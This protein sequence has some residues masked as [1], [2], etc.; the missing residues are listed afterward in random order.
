[1][2]AQHETWRT[3]NGVDDGRLAERLLVLSLHERLS[4]L[5][6]WPA[7]S[8]GESEAAYRRV[9][10]VVAILT[11]TLT[12]IGVSLIWE[13]VVVKV[14][15]GER[16]EALLCVD[17]GNGSTNGKESGE[18]GSGDHN[19]LF[20]YEGISASLG[21]TGQGR[22]KDQVVRPR[23]RTNS[24]FRYSSPAAEGR[25]QRMNYGFRFGDGCLLPICLQGLLLCTWL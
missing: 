17:E 13:V 19:A 6:Q 7:G 25:A 22:G 8:S 16:N 12:V 1:M 11:A 15:R 14:L 3:V 10:D 23:P 5:G 21:R 9:A 24:L 20:F 4:V 2:S 18:G